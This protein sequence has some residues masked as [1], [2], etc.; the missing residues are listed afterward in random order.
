MKKLLKKFLQWLS[1]KAYGNFEF[2]NKPSIP[3]GEFRV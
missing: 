3:E 1:R 2:S